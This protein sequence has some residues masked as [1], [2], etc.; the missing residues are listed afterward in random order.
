L[1][2]GQDAKSS[3]FG[4]TVIAM[5]NAAAQATVQ[6][7]VPFKPQSGDG[8]EEADIEQKVADFTQ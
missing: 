8:R 5:A 2:H 1:P 6:R 7:I 4:K 3:T